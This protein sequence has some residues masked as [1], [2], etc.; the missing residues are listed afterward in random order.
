M[1]SL[2]VFQRKTVTAPLLALPDSIQR[3]KQFSKW[4]DTAITI[5]FINKR[6][7]LDPFLSLIPIAGSIVSG[8][9]SLYILYVGW[10]LQLPG[11]V[12]FKMVVNILIDVA[13]GELPVVG[14]VLD[15]M[16]RSNTKNA[17]LLEKAY[18]AHS[19]PTVSVVMQ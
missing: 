18:H 7:G 6:I 8:A 9:L 2:G 12:L 13:V 15:A 11:S 19:R 10:S 17:Q 5:P 14:A 3:V 16:W 1:F 4:L